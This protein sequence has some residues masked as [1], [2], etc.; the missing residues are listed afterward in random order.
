MQHIALAT[1]EHP[2]TTVAASAG[3][4]IGQVVTGLTLAVGEG[5][6]A[7]A[8]D[9]RRQELRTLL[10]TGRCG[11]QATGEHH[12]GQVR[13]EQQAAADGLHDDH[14]FHGTAGEAA[15]LLRERQAEQPQFGVAAPEL[16][17]PAFG[18]AQVAG[19][20]LEAIAIGDQPVDRILEHALF[21]VQIEI[22]A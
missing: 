19:P 12:R 21:F 15:V 16:P 7:F 20:L 9:Q 11:Q 13:F 4:H 5:K 14:G 1:I 18:F 2:V 17:A 10:G 3:I 8:G 22:H 6:Q